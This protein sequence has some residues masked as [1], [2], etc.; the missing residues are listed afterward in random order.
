[1]LMICLW[2]QLTCSIC[3]LFLGRQQFTP[4]EVILLREELKRCLNKAEVDAL[5]S[6][7]SPFIPNKEE[8]KT[9]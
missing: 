5:N 9:K 3:T 8:I 1:M 4:E 6:G 7:S 2:V